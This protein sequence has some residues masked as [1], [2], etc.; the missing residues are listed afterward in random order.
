ML[1]SESPPGPSCSQASALKSDEIEPPKFSI[2]NY[3]FNSR[4][5]DIQRNWPFPQKFLQVCS[6]HGVKD[7]LPPF[8]SRGSVRAKCC[9]KDIETEQLIASSK[10]VNSFDVETDNILPLK[11]QLVVDISDHSTQHFSEKERLVVEQVGILDGKVIHDEAETLSM[12]PSHDQVERKSDKISE[13]QFVETSELDVAVSPP[14]A[15]GSNVTP[16]RAEKKRKLIVKLSTIPQSSRAEDIGATSACVSDLMASKVCPVCKTF[17]SSSNTTLNAHIDQCLSEE[18]NTKLAVANSLKHQVKP[19]KKKLMVD[20]Y[21]TAPQCTLEDLDRRNG[22]NW[23]LDSSLVA[24]AGNVSCEIKRPKLSPG[25][26]DDGNEGAVY[27]DSNGIKIRI[28]SKFDDAPPM[29][30]SKGFM[31]RKDAKDTKAGKGFLNKKKHLKAKCLK[32]LKVNAPKKKL[33]SL[34]LHRHKA[35]SSVEGDCHL[36]THQKIQ[37]EESL[38]EILNAQDQVQSFGPATL[39]QWVCSKRSEMSRKL[40]NKEFSKSP[41]NPLPITKKLSNNQT[42]LDNT[43]VGRK[44]I[45]MLSRLSED[46]A[47]SN[48]T[49]RVDILDDMVQTTNEKNKSPKLPV[50]DPLLA[51]DGASVA[52][53]LTLQVS[54]SSCN[55]SSP[56]SLR[57]EIHTGTT[58]KSH[59]SSC[60][61]MLPVESCHPSPIAGKESS[62]KS[63]LLES[64][65]F[66][67]VDGDSTASKNLLISKKLRKHRSIGSGKWGRELPS[68]DDRLA[69]SVKTKKP[70][71]H[72]EVNFSNGTVIPGTSDAVC[73]VPS[74]TIGITEFKQENGAFGLQK[75]TMGRSDFRKQLDMQDG[76]LG[77]WNVTTEPVVE[78]LA[79]GDAATDEILLSDGQILDVNTKL[80]HLSSSKGHSEPICGNKS[81]GELPSQRSVDAEQMQC[82]D[83]VNNG[84]N[85]QSTWI[86]GK[87]QF[88][89]EDTSDLQVEECQTGSA[90]IE[91]SNTCSKE[92]VGCGL[93]ISQEKSLVTSKKILSDEKHRKLTNR[94]PSSSPDSTASTISHPSQDFEVKDKEVHANLDSSLKSIG[95]E[96]QETWKVNLELN[97]ISPVRQIERFRDS[98]PCFC[99]CRE[100]LFR[101]PQFVRQCGTSKT[102]LLSKGIQTSS[103]MHIQRVISSSSPCPC[104]KT[105]NIAAP[106]LESTTSSILSRTSSDSAM[107]LSSSADL[108]SP[109]ALSGNQIQNPILRLMGKDLVVNKDVTTTELPGSDFHRI[110]DVKYNPLEH[111]SA[112]CTLGQVSFPCYYHWP[113]DSSPFPCQA[114]WTVNHQMCF[115]PHGMMFPAGD[116]PVT[117]SKGRHSQQSHQKR[118]L[119][120][121]LNERVINPPAA[122][123]FPVNLSSNLMPHSSLYSSPTSN[124]PFLPTVVIRP[125]FSTPRPIPPAKMMRRRSLPDGLPPLLPNTFPSPSSDHLT[126]FY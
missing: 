109:N 10:D 71:D 89:V 80:D 73:H 29:M 82:D 88:L 90:T 115:Q 108:N 23:A 25:F 96:G 114:S 43:S 44:H 32:Y 38:S 24:P 36:N 51:S 22:T 105:N 7:L 125:S 59:I 97:G 68:Y 94:D 9:R 95:I 126:P 5:Q 55:L 6:K 119:N 41:E 102:A 124:H 117:S 111:S 85:D 86:E 2:R 27:V 87:V 66:M 58:R 99:S 107:K 77:C 69:G 78:K 118:S 75:Y 57:T 70:R 39:G 76:S 16:Q 54:K 122:S 74:T 64:P 123:V 93:E 106:L 48:S 62:L 113:S 72:H 63:D 101:E 83:I 56:A 31:L 14:V 67:V 13:K 17:A 35:E 11:D 52:A 116:S 121:P 46:P 8:E 21:K 4:N 45:L 53:G 65:S 110:T 92:H 19:R 50:S 79:V 98:Q 100:S 42:N 61:T 15:E 40:K 1:S 37:K 120:Q 91:R 26:I 33:S 60:L 47:P 28:L 112:D 34:K 30:S 49:K 84:I 104:F 18:S 12:I 103:N 3:V 20:I 81:Q